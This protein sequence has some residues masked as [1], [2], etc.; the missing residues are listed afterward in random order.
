MSKEI[1]TITASYHKGITNLT[2]APKKPTIEIDVSTFYNG[3]DKGKSV[4]I[5]LPYDLREVGYFH[6]DMDETKHLI[7][8]LVECIR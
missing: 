6:L 5:T 4:Q 7:E 2:Q 8:L 3:K 1:G